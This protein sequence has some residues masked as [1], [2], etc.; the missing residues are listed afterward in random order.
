MIID[1]SAVFDFAGICNQDPVYIDGFKH[2]LMESG[3][4]AKMGGAV[5]VVKK[6]TPPPPA[7]AAS[8]V[9]AIRAALWDNWPTGEFVKGH[10]NRFAMTLELWD[11]PADDIEVVKVRSLN[12]A[13]K[14]NVSLMG[15]KSLKAMLKH[16]RKPR[17]NTLTNVDP[18]YLDGIAAVA[19]ANPQA[20]IGL[21]NTNIHDDRNE[22]ARGVYYHPNQLVMVEMDGRDVESAKIVLTDGGI[23]LSPFV[24]TDH[25]GEPLT[26]KIAAQSRTDR[27]QF[28]PTWDSRNA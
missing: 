19:E 12:F 18:D 10:P 3:L 5:P 27:I 26:G 15:R 22:Y 6:T 4:W 17:I 9:T 7:P 11:R 23:A 16:L 28:D 14:T 1:R 24:T 8:S 2:A 21:I 20:L 25:A 13:F